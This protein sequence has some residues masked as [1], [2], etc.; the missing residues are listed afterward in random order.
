MLF[1]W[2]A[3]F[4]GRRTPLEDSARHYDMTLFEEIQN[5]FKASQELK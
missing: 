4:I 2:R 3:F 1:L 5:T